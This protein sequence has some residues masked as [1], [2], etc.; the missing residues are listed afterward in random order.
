[1]DTTT[2]TGTP[3]RQRMIE[4]MRMRKLEF[5][6]QEGYIGAVRKLTVYLKRSPDTATVEATKRRRESGLVHWP[7]ARRQPH[8]VAPKLRRALSRRGIGP[9]ARDVWALCSKGSIAREL[10]W[11][12]GGASSLAALPVAEMTNQLAG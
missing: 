7:I 1:M 12:R 9:S 2:H 5:R 6:S 11:G 10:R 3:L 4:D 8:R